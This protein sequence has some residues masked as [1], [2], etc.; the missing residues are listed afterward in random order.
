MP[1]WLIVLITVLCVVAILAFMY[2]VWALRRMSIVSKKLDY[3]IE[4]LTYKSEKMN[5]VVSSI[6]K[7]SNYINAAEDLVK[8]NADVI[9]KVML[10]KNDKK[11][12]NNSKDINNEESK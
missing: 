10:E 3:L 11:L 5:D 12:K 8:N 1:T 7:I 6:V 4:D 2:F 9:S